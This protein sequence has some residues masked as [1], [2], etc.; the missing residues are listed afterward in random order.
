M[1]INKNYNSDKNYAHI[2][3]AIKEVKI[4]T[5]D[6]VTLALETLKLT[7]I[8]PPKSLQQLND[9]HQQHGTG[10]TKEVAEKLLKLKNQSLNDLN[11]LFS[12]SHEK[13]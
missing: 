7:S 2:Q 11:K 4:N 8:E 6:S 5:P 9:V 3:R 13:N 1:T 10:R 12:Q